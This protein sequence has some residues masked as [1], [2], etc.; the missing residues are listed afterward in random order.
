MDRIVVHVCG[1]ILLHEKEWIWVSW[2]EVD[3]P[4]VCYTDWSQSEREK[5][6]LYIKAYICN[7]K[8]WYRWTYLQGQNW[9]GVI[10]IGLV[11][12]AGE[13]EG[14][15]NWQSSIDMYILHV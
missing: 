9:D 1:G 7:L 2:T 6:I 8:K 11:D 5:Q 15:M 12:T 3:E 13:G 10:E 4:E 14:G